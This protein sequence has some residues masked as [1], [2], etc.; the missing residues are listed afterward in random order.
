LTTPI[1]RCVKNQLG[2][3]VHFLTKKGFESVLDH[4]EYIDKKIVFDGNIS[5]I[6]AILRRESY[7]LVID[8][9]KNAKSRLIRSKIEV[10]SI[11]FDKLN[12]KKWLLTTFKIN[13][14]PKRHLVDR[15]FDAV[16][17]IGVVNDGHGCDFTVLDDDISVINRYN[18][19]SEYNVLVL[20]A[21]YF[22]KRIPE[23]KCKEI[24]DLSSL[25]IVL[26]GGK[27]VSE[28]GGSLSSHSGGKVYNLCGLISLR[29]S[30]A[31]M[32]TSE[33]VITADTG[34]MHI[35]A[36]LRCKIDVIWG[37]TTPDFGMYPYLP[38]VL[39]DEYTN[40]EVKGLRCRPCSKLGSDRCPKGH[41]K[42]MMEQDFD[43]MF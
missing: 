35:A 29:E 31:V 10:K 13:R 43:S 7:D 2:A 12:V 18:L 11:T 24:I 30:A 28:L 25:P 6:S 15:Y 9:Q 19:P 39:R 1:I 40:H 22:T 17:E 5:E 26:I 34:M 16:K 32:E 4:N 21:T 42:C 37:N 38:K 23:E 3:E 20:G 14:L 8:L 33:R 41:F 27:D 36:A